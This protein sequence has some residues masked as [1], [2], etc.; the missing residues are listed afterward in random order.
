MKEPFNEVFD[1]IHNKISINPLFGGYHHV[2][3]MFIID[4]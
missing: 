4:I 2:A 3:N 1:S